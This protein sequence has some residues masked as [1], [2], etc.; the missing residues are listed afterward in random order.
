LPNIQVNLSF[1]GVSPITGDSFQLILPGYN[2]DNFQIFLDSLS[3]QNPEEFKILVLDN[4]VFHKAKK[5]RV[6]EN[7]AFVFLATK[8]SELNPPEKM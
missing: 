8:S 3:T 5:S 6:P 1:W 2:A 7:I 4:G